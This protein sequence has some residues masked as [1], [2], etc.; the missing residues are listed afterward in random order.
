MLKR[1]GMLAVRRPRTILIAFLGLRGIGVVLSGSVKDRLGVGG[2]VAPA[3]ESARADAFLDQKFDATPNFVLQVVARNNGTVANPDVIAAAGRLERLAESQGPAKVIGSFT[4]GSATDL[5]SL[6]GH[7]GLILVHMEGSD[8]DAAKVANRIM[9]SLPTDD[10][11]VTVRAGGS[12]GVLREIENR[13]NHDLVISESIALP[14]A[15]AV[16]VVVFGGL[17]AALLPLAVGI[18]S[19]VTTLL[20][21]LAMTFGIDVSIHAM[22]VATAFGLG[23]SIDF[24]LLM[25]SRFREERDSGRDHQ[26]A[27]IATVTSA[28]RT[29]VFSAATIT[30]AM[31]GLLVFPTYFLRSIGITASAVVIFSALSAIVV[32]PALLSLFGKRIDGVAVV[33]RKASPSADS[34][35]WRRMAQ[36]VT[37]RPVACALPVVAVLLALGI[38]FLTVKL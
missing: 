6:D 12:I 18:T 5:R 24:G 30:L 21:L 4:Q 36:V 7:S 11:Y 31:A 23:L 14:A 25:V 27:I 37:G 26:S 9:K 17:V 13:V 28:G 22:T 29:I 35:F 1:A 2:F 34:A 19:I 15:L 10:P 38:P 32:L 33:R 3:T 16:L 8:D 20:V